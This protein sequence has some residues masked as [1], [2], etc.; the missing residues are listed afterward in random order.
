MFTG[1]AADDI[2][3]ERSGQGTVPSSDTDPPP[4]AER[5]G[6]HLSPLMLRQWIA[7]VDAGYT[8]EIGTIISCHT[9]HAYEGDGELSGRVSKHPVGL[10]YDVVALNG[11]PVTP[12][13]QRTP[14]FQAFLGA[15]GAFPADIA[16]S[17]VI[18]LMDPDGFDGSVFLAQP[19]HGDHV[20]VEEPTPGT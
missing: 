10:A 7:L 14:V 18:S 3:R 5:Y 6:R 4:A 20:H 16:P 15:I 2:A 9:W 17:R 12:E 8:I 11:A 1:C 13:L 19:N